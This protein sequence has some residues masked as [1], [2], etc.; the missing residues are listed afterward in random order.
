M[1]TSILAEEKITLNRV[2][3]II[4]LALLV[5]VLVIFGTVSCKSS[6]EVEE[7]G[8]VAVKEGAINFEGSVK[9]VLGKY[10]FLPEARGF[11]IM[12]QGNLES[13]DIDTLVDKKVRG[14]GEVTPERPSVLVANTIE[15]EDESGAFTNVFTRSEEPVF[16]DYLSI[17]QRDE[18]KILEDLSYEKKE[19]WEA[20]E[21]AKVYG[22][23]EQEEEEYRIVIFNDSGREIGK[24]VVDNFSDYGMYYVKKLRLF[25]TFWFYFRVKETVDWA[26]RRR[27]REMFHADVLFAGLF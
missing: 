8:V 23:L 12:V 27:T 14:E 5:F 18:F 21:N 9:V 25:D 17:T 6:E 7:E 19:I 20:Q 3:R 26:V 16:E 11:D 1:I 24:I 4:G 10:I 22:K 13:G 2:S 15:I